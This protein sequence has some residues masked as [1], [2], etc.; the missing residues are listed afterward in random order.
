MAIAF[1]RKLMV[2]TFH[3]EASSHDNDFQIIVFFWSYIVISN[4]SSKEL[5]GLTIQNMGE[6]TVQPIAI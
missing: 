4:V 5:S 6:T 2:M 1:S 3:E